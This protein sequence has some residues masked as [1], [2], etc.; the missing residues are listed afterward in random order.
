[1]KETNIYW[2][3]PADQSQIR[4]LVAETPIGP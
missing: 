2:Q 3:Q 1:M 4:H